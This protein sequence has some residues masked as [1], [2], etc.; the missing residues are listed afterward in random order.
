[1]HRQ[2]RCPCRKKVCRAGGQY[3]TPRCTALWLAW[4]ETPWLSK[5]ITC[6]ME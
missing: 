2:R 5:V 6:D 4:P 3:R 1:M